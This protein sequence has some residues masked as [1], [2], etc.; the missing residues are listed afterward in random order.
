[1]C[2]CSVYI[3]AAAH[4]LCL[5]CIFSVFCVQNT[6]QYMAVTYLDAATFQVTYQLKVLTTALF[7]VS[8]LGKRLSFLQWISLV[9]VH[10]CD[11]RVCV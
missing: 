3:R 9:R 5:C 2:A 7:S 8:L 6:L 10:V 1:M 4:A 11:R